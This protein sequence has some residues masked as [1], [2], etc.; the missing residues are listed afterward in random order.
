[1]SSD[2][3]VL[4]NRL[5]LALEVAGNKPW[6]IRPGGK[7]FIVWEIG[8]DTIWREI[9]TFARKEDAEAFVFMMSD[10]VLGEWS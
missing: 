9:A 3:R 8:A 7:A 1:M 5:K 2:H 6:R 4:P 10:P